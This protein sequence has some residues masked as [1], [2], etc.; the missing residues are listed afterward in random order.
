MN[1]HQIGCGIPTGY[2]AA[3]KTAEVKAGS[4]CAVWGLGALGLAALMGCKNA[5]ASKIIAID[6]N[7]DK[8]EIAKKL[9]A[10]DF[11]N[12]KDLVGKTVPQHLMEITGGGLDYTFEAVG[13]IATM[14][15]A[16]ESTTIG[17]GVCILIGVAPNDQEISLLPMNFLL[18]KSLK[19]TLFGSYK[20]GDS[21]P[22]LVEEYLSGQL[23]VDEFITHKITLE[24]INYGFNLMREG[25]SIRSVIKNAS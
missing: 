22:K 16:F 2:G 7:S 5:G 20:S 23:L 11:L 14:K 18:G 25:K 10:T 4:S 15:Q 3:R 9:G 13:T 19:G 17:Y 21:I 12:P 6:I 8:F 1:I 24:E